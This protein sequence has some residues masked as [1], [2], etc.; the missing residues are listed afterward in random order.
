MGHRWKRF[1]SASEGGYGSFP[2][3]FAKGDVKGNG[4]AGVDGQHSAPGGMDDIL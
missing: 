4:I 1:A 2:F 3:G